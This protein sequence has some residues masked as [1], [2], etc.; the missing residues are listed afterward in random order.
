[1][2][3]DYIKPCVCIDSFEIKS[4]ILE[5]SYAGGAG[6]DAP[7]ETDARQ[8]YGC[9]ATNRGGSRGYGSNG[10]NGSGWGSLW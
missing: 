1:M 8:R 5:G 10:S 7:K 9:G 6:D 4:C 2:K 3:K